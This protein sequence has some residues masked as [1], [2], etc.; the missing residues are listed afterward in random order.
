V[1]SSSE[2][3]AKSPYERLR[4]GSRFYD[5]VVCAPSVTGK[6]QPSR[7]FDSF[8]HEEELDASNASRVTSDAVV[9]GLSVLTCW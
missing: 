2:D 8:E 7:T 3:E 1:F 5:G 6:R 4:V 9:A